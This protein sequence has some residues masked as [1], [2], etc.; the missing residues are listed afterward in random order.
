VSDAAG[1]WSGA[2][3]IS[4]LSP[5]DREIGRPK[6]NW[7]REAERTVRLG[8][9]ERNNVMGNWAIVNSTIVNSPKAPSVRDLSDHLSSAREMMAKRGVEVDHVKLSCWVLK[10]VP[11]LEQN[12]E[13]AS[14]PWCPLIWRS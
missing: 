13:H 11:M 9:T 7:C 3:G 5:S 10:Y 4:R 1:L 2:R 6:Q 8:S 14:G 12:F